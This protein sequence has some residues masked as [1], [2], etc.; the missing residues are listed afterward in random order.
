MANDLDHVLLCLFV[1]LSYTIFV[2]IIVYDF[3]DSLIKV[4]S[5]D[6]RARPLYALRVISRTEIILVLLNFKAWLFIYLIT[7][8]SST[9]PLN[10][11]HPDPLTIPLTP[12]PL[13]WT[14]P[15]LL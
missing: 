9:Y 7:L 3:T 2:K 12:S 14:N 10:S 1:L 11:C 5:L 4:V 13:R 6:S 8:H 15:P